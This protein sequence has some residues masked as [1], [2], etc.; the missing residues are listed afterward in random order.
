[1]NY[2][3]YD[4]VALGNHELDYGMPQ[5]F[6]ITEALDAPV[7]CANFMNMLYGN[8]AQEHWSV[9]HQYRRYV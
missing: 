2:V 6:K 5:V 8:I 3:G 9:D 1:M 4:V 7:V